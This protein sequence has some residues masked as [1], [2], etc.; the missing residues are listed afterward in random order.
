M[1]DDWTSGVGSSPEVLYQALRSM[2]GGSGQGPMAGMPGMGDMG[3]TPG[4]DAMG[5]M[6]GVPGVGGVG[7]SDLLGGDAGD[8]TCWDA[9]SPG[10]G[11]STVVSLALL[12]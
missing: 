6:P 11:G 9:R 1:L 10:S 8:I 4:M 12:T 7:V 5:S 3:H 2:S